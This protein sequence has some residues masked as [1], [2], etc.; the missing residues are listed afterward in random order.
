M[1]E[2]ALAGN[3]NCGKTTLFNLLTDSREHTGNRP[4]VTV[5]VKR[6]I[7]S[8]GNISAI[9]S[10]LPGIYSLY[11]YSQDETIACEYILKDKPDCIINV[12]DATNME[13]NMYLT[14]Q[15]MQTGIPVVMALNMIDEAENRGDVI[16]IKK[17]EELMG[18]PVIPISALKKKGIDKLII[19]AASIS[20]KRK[21]PYALYFEE[22]DEMYEKEANRRYKYIEKI[23]ALCVHKGKTEHSLSNRIDTVVTNR[24]L[25]FPIF[26]TIM[27]FVFSVTFGNVGKALS[28]GMDILVNEKIGALTANILC[29]L[30]VSE[31]ITAL[32]IDGIIKGIGMVIVFLPQIV[33]LFL[34]LSIL[35]DTGYM[36]RASFITDRLLRSF[37]LSGR[38]F[39]PMLMG[40]GCSVPA[41]MATRTLKSRT[42]RNKT[43]ILIPFMT[44]GARMAVFAAFGNEIFADKGRVVTAALYVIGIGVALLSGLIL[45]NTFIKGEDEGFITELPPYRLPSL[46]SV[47]IHMCERAEDFIKKVFTTLL[48]ASVIIWLMQSFDIRL[49]IVKDNSE[50]IFACL[51]KAIA[52]IFIPCG[53]GSDWRKT[54]AIISGLGAK[55][56]IIS[57]LGILYADGFLSRHFTGLSAF[58]Y[59]VFI[60]LYMPCAAAFTAS[61]KE[62]KSLK[63]AVFAA[64]YQTAAAW[65]VSAAVYQTGSFILS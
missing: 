39:V 41:I 5:D 11:P 32:I 35:E 1:L 28:N 38:S 51:G 22:N 36:A 20:R 29:E 6:G 52:P 18:I 24:F 21:G 60:L 2:F 16:D 15:L 8:V 47:M 40:F 25:A 64:L 17:M 63:W 37:G 49:N 55:E 23:T 34:F 14:T 27:Y 3:P 45:G 7:C 65:L 59:L 58:S 50:S 48:V 62:M 19:K 10:D 33:L 13:R 12:V 31:L 42:E 44:C 30:N 9:I 4:G 46:Y 43:V 57:T 54:A 53:F 26:M 56:A 61:Y